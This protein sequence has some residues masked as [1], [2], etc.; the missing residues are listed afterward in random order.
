MILCSFFSNS[1]QIAAAHPAAELRGMLRAAACCLGLY[2]ED[3]KTQYGAVHINFCV[4]YLP[5]I[6]A[7]E[8]AGYSIKIRNGWSR[9]V[10]SP[11][12]R[13]VVEN[14]T[15]E[16]AVSHGHIVIAGGGG[17]IPVARDEK[18]HLEGGFGSPIQP[19]QISVTIAPRYRR[20]P[21]WRGAQ[22]RSW[23]LGGA[24]GP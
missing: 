19:R 12:P 24:L 2:V 9:V 13:K 3:S 4:G 7:A 8:L 16:D 18:G 17:V 5:F 11:R 21:S 14:H 10:S 1:S 22:G 6:P 15:I 23:N 20:R